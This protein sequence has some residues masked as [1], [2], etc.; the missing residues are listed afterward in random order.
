MNQRKF[1]HFFDG[2]FGT[3]Y[4]ESGGCHEYCELANLDEGEL[5]RQIHREYIAAGATAIK[6]NTFGANSFLLDGRQT[7]EIIKKGFALATEAAAAKAT[8]FADIGGIHTEPE[9]AQVEY[10]RIADLFLQCGAKHFL[11]ETLPELSPVLPATAAIKERDPEAE[12]IV[13]FAVS[14]DGYT[15]SGLYYKELIAAAA[16]VPGITACGLN[17]ICGPSHLLT[18]IR[19]LDLTDVCFS[20][21]PNAGYPQTINGRTFYRNN[22]VYFSQKL[23]EIYCAGATIVGGCCGTTPEHIRLAVDAIRKEQNGVPAT[24]LP[25]VSAPLPASRQNSFADKLKNK[26]RVIAVELDPP[27]TPDISFQL[28]AAQKIAEAGGD[29]I[30]VA[31]SP[32]SRARA[33]SLITAARI[34]RDTGMEVLPHLTC[35]DRNHIGIKSAL[36]GAGIEHVHNVLA[37]TGDPVAQTDRNRIKSVFSMNSF[38]LISFIRSLNDEIFF[39]DPYQIGAALNINAPSFDAEL[40]RAQRKVESGA[41]FFLSQAIFSPAAVENLDRAARKLCVPVLAGILPIA[42]YKNAVFLNNE[43]SGITIQDELIQRLK[44]Q[45]PDAAREISLEYSK[46]IIDSVAGTAGGFYLMTPLKKVDLVCELIRYIRQR[47]A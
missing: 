30:T 29:V 22:A 7:E 35:R 25:A 46:K 1:Q 12:I 10:L 9:I 14:Q 27:L 18:L 41:N 3:Y 32:L 37:I 43:V 44:D 5:V 17:C 11:F 47:H 2:A 42:G 20:A 38:Q 4:F 19:Q 28:G 13:S 15:Q 8:V 16:S 21:M 6:T 34:H 24:T 31:D 39:D 33:D 45:P 40:E 23:K 26:N 36:V